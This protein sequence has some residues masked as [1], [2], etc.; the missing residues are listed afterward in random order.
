VETEPLRH[1]TPKFLAIEQV[2]EVLAVA[3]DEPGTPM[4]PALVLTFFCGVRVAEVRRLDWNAIRT[5]AGEEGVGLNPELTKHGTRRWIRLHP[6]A[7]AWL[8]RH[9]GPREGAVA[10][11]AW[12]FR[13]ERLVAQAGFR[14]KARTSN[15]GETPLGA[16]RGESGRWQWPPNGLRHS[17]CSYAVAHFRN[18]AE[19][20]YWGGT[21]ERILRRDYIGLVTESE[22]T[23][24]FA[25][26]PEVIENFRSPT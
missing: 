15:N 11:K 8:R 23:R 21:S 26:T 18:L 25:L 19:V 3:L 1:S 4:L 13:R 22:G 14:V 5:T 24:Y 20:A 10:P 6:V 12:N 17:Y 9:T 16:I 2:A 7:L